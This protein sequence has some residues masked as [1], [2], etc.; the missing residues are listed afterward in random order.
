MGRMKELIAD[1]ET[2]RSCG[3]AGVV[4]TYTY[5]LDYPHITGSMTCEVCNGSKMTRRVD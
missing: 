5:I 2:C 1:W 4:P 3:G